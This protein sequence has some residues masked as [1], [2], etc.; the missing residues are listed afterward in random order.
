MAV[1]SCVAQGFKIDR[2]LIHQWFCEDSGAVVV[3]QTTQE[4]L[5]NLE[6]VVAGCSAHPCLSSEPVGER[7]RPFT[8]PFTVA[9]PCLRSG[10][11]QR[12]CFE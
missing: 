11:R 2:L 6:K 1:R 5:T 3:S 7:L 12:T 9:S 8:S 4:A 10:F